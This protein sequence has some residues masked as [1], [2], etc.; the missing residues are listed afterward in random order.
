MIYLLLTIL[1]G[2]MLS[3][4]MRLSEGRVKYRTGMLAGNYFTCML[5]AV[6]FLG[7]GNVFSGGEG[8]GR[9]LGMGAVNGAFFLSALMC[10][11][12]CIRRAGVV[13]PSVFSK[14][15]S[16][17]VPLVVSILLFKETPS[18]LQGIGSVLALSGVLMMNLRR[19][20]GSGGCLGML[21]AL[22]FTEGMA[23]SMTKI[24]REVGN[25]AL[26]DHFLLFTFASAFLLCMAV[27]LLRRER[28]GLRELAFGA[29]IGVPNFLSTRFILKAL[30]RLPAIIVY[31]SR[32]VGTIAVIALA[33]TLVF[34]EKLSRRQKLALL[35]ILVALALL[36]L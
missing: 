10:S 33:G 1:C 12:Y 16:L 6:C 9:A 31:P 18:A 23:S 2:S 5:M 20:G 21:I 35:V 25:P 19:G 34:R 32:S 15:G 29:M 22:L 3:I 14:T 36:N 13:L 4:V 30:E 8:F 24:Y 26:S 17:L 27:V 7:P 28:P 11:Q